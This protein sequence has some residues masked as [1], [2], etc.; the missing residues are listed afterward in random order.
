M[1]LSTEYMRKLK[2]STAR[3]LIIIYSEK[4]RPIDRIKL[5]A[6]DG[7]FFLKAKNAKI[8]KR[9]L[10]IIEKDVKIAKKLARIIGENGKIAGRDLTA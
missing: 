1:G 9:I 6:L 7:S 8:V 5:I 3:V 10:L 4:T 2:I